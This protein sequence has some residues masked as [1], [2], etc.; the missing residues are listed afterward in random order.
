M[1]GYLQ[2]ASNELSRLSAQ[3]TVQTG[4]QIGSFGPQAGNIHSGNSG[5]ESHHE[6]GPGTLQV[7]I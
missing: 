1:S 6:N 5:I 7:V 3:Q 2:K 4:T